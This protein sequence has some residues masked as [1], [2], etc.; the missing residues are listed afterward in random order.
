NLQSP[1]SSL[2]SPISI[3]SVVLRVT[4]LSR[5][6]KPRRL[7]PLVVDEA[8][9]GAEFQGEGVEAQVVAPGGEGA[10]GAAP[11][12]AEA[13]VGGGG[14]VGVEHPFEVAHAALQ[15]VVQPG[16]GAVAAAALGE[17]LPLVANPALEC[18]GE[19][20]AVGFG[21]VV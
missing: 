8:V 18:F 12:A 2:Q 1:I 14:V 21:L 10:E 5:S 4:S 3:L 16:Q 15:R 7:R 6:L 17:L 20:E 11:A 19:G 9:E 13:R